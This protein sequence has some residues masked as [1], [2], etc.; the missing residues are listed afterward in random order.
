MALHPE[1][2][3]RDADKNLVLD[4][5]GGRRA[6]LAFCGIAVLRLPHHLAVLGVERHESGIGLM[7]ENF[8]VGIGEPPVDRIAAHD[9][10]DVRILL[11]LVLPED[12]GIVVQVERINRVGKRSVHVHDVAYDERPSFVAAQDA[13]GERPGDLQLAGI[14]RSDLLELGIALIG[15]ISRRHHPVLRVLRH[16]DEL[17]VRMRGARGEQRHGTQAGRQQKFVHRKA[18]SRMTH[19]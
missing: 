14:L 7:Q 12:L 4:Y 3:A 15:V 19:G 10:D 11:G 13:G 5:H 2:A 9:R 18:P 6:G 16:L 1:L 8:S 17:V